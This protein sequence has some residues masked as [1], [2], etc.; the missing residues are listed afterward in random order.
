MREKLEDVWDLV[1]EWVLGPSELVKRLRDSSTSEQ[2]KMIVVRRLKEL[3]KRKVV[4]AEELIK[5]EFVIRTKS[6][7]WI[8]PQ[9]ALLPSEYKPYTNVERLVKAGLLDS[10]LVE[11]VDPVFIEN[12]NED[13]IA[14]WKAFLEDLKVGSDENM[15]KRI[16]ENVGIRVALK[17]EREV[18]NSL[19]GIRAMISSLKCLT[20]LQST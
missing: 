5:E 9:K 18:Y 8:E 6:S 20:A 7:K 15:I 14:E 16:V 3:W 10:D 2:E 4:S 19:R 17:Y 13:E 1:I 11:F 12:A